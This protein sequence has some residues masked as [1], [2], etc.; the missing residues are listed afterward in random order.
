M[1]FLPPPAQTPRIPIWVVGAW[2][3]EKSMER[4]LRYD[5]LLPYK[6]N[7]DGTSADIT[8]ADIA[9]MKA[10]V[11][12]RRTETTPYDIVWEG[13]TP[14]DDPAA[15]A[16]MVQP[17]VAAGITWWMEAM[18]DAMRDPTPVRARIRQGPPRVD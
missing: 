12:E 5:G 15:A 16:A 13:K 8:P 18:W 2:P 7:S 6:L 11:T 17:Y 4:A 9:A 3:R 10:Y 1:T 14:G